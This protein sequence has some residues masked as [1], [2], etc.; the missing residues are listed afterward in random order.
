MASRNICPGWRSPLA[1]L[2]L[3]ALNAAHAAPPEFF[4][5]KLS[6]N[7]VSYKTLQEAEQ[8]YSQIWCMT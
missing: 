4:Q 8:S 7:G 5:Y 3:I 1:L 2:L 6:L